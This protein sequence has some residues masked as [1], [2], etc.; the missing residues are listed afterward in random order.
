[1][2]EMGYLELFS[3]Q[4]VVSLEVLVAGFGDDLGQERR[5]GRLL[6]PIE[7]L[8]VIPD[9]LFVETGLAAAGLIPVG[10]PETGG[11]RRQH[12]VNEQQTPLIETELELGVGDDDAAL[13][14]VGAGGLVNAQ[15]ELAD[16]FGCLGA[17][18]R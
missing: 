10:R 7:R 13:P 11:I 14:R 6:V 5:R 16:L 9:K 4:Q 18:Q 8:E 1:M 15:T 2:Y 3:G 12:L 17:D